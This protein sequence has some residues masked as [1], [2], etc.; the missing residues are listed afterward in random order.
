M[1]NQIFFNGGFH[2]ETEKLLSVQDRGLCFGDGLFEVIRCVGGRFLLFSQHLARMRESAAFLR[3]EFPYGDRELLD[4]CAE[5]SRRNGVREGE[6]YLEFTRGEAP[7]Y[8]LFPSGI[9]PNFF[10]M[11][12]PL[13][14]MPENAWSAGVATVTYPDIRWG[15]CHL[16][17]I[18]LL[19]NVLG[20]QF[21]KEHGAFE[22]LFYREGP[23]GRYLSE[24]P[25]STI[26]AVKDGALLTPDLDNIL[27][28]TTRKHVLALA[29]EDGMAVREGRLPL[30]TFLGADE[31]FIS[32]TVSEVM[33]VA[34]VDG[35]PVGAGRRG[36]V[37]ERLQQLYAGFKAAHLEG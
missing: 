25:S 5:L 2:P 23:Q 17:T 32:S 35:A 13:R 22:A 19:P 28:G 15:C 26:F 9:R 37:T 33:P 1:A 29:R 34:R 20:K 36:P 18:N 14:A 3:M 4:A 8:H 11:L 21:A 30:E 6:L 27:P 10:M 12:N 16:K 24:G 7:R 31:A